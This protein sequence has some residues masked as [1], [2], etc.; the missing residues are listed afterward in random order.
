MLM[1]CRESQRVA[2]VSFKIWT[3]EYTDSNA[4]V[5]VAICKAIWVIAKT[6]IP[7]IAQKRTL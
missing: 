7:A 4:N 1:R 6:N 5:A 3:D 2:Y